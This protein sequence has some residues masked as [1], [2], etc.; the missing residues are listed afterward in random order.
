M[1][2]TSALAADKKEKP[3][4]EFTFRSSL[5]TRTHGFTLSEAIPGI[6]LKATI[7]F[8][9]FKLYGVHTAEQR[10]VVDNRS[11]LGVEFPKF[12]NSAFPSIASKLEY[13]FDR[14]F[15]KESYTFGMEFSRPLTSLADDGK[16]VPDFAFSAT[17]QYLTKDKKRE[18]ERKL[19]AYFTA[20]LKGKFSVQE[21]S[22]L[23]LSYNLNFNYSTQ[24]VTGDKIDAYGEVTLTLPI[25]TGANRPEFSLL[26][27][28]GRRPGDS[29]ATA[30]L[31]AGLK[32]R[33]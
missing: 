28:T 29:K 16:H 19:G 6:R 11:V 18:N 22:D 2:A 8:H 23:Q 33:F 21:S 20:G 17:A 12:G 5:D 15:D 27:G 1:V 32:F 31:E 14:F 30:R 4:F 13:K 3:Q 9:E 25:G 10:D 26:Y 24:F 7:P